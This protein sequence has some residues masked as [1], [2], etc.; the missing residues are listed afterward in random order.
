[1]VLAKLNSQAIQPMI[2]KQNGTRLATLVRQSYTGTMDAVDLTGLTP[3]RIL[4]EI[5]T[6][7]LL[8]CHTFH[9]IGQYRLCT[10][11]TK[12]TKAN[13]EMIYTKELEIIWFRRNYCPH[14]QNYNYSF[15]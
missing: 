12:Y 9:L 1:M 6:E 13:Y 5:G 3:L 11:R 2:H 8:R 14:N 7:K 10:L 4:A 15:R